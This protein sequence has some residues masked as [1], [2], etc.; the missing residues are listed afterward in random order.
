MEGNISVSFRR[1]P[2]YFAG[3][4]LQGDLVQVITCRDTMQDHILGLGSRCSA[5]MHINGQAMR[6]GYLSDLRGDPAYRKGTL[7]AR[8]FRFLRAL[9]EADPLPFYY[10]LILESNTS[11]LKNLLGARA[12]LPV[13]TPM[14][15]ILTPA[16]H[17]DFAKPAIIIANVLLRQASAQD[18]PMIIR[19]LDRKMPNRQCS[20]VY[21]VADFLPGGRCTG[22]SATD[23]YLACRDGVIVGVIAAW[24]QASIRQTHVEK[25]SPALAALR[26]FY[27]LASRFTSLKSLPKKG[28]RVP[29]LYLS[30]IAIEDDN[31]ELFRS[32]LRY[33]Y[34][35]LRSGPWHYAIIGLHEQDP[36]AMVLAEY[37]SIHAAGLLFRVDFDTASVNVQPLILDHRI[38][39]IEMAL[40]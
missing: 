32:L 40:A 2:S 10:T 17:L 36:L 15:R 33:T 4:Q 6:A 8:G 13:Y 24:D 3:C 11:A 27:N 20:P 22:L 23:F 14:G 28:D 29:Y 25:Y 18:L 21:R 7:L 26:P 34:N 35:Q 37:R 9:H 16:I 5:E 38:P 19:F 39:Y 31:P 1:E 30:C 12:G